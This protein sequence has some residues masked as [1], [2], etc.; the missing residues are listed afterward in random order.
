MSTHR[1]LD[2]LTRG[3]DPG[4]ALRLYILN[5][6]LYPAWH[7]VT[8][9]GAYDPW[10]VWWGVGAF[11]VGVGL[12]AG[13][14]QSTTRAREHGT[15]ACSWLVTL[16]FFLLAFANDMHPFYAVGSLMAVVFAPLVIR[17]LPA[18]RSYTVFVAC[19]GVGLFALEPQTIKVAFWAPLGIVLAFHY[20]RI[21]L[22]QA[23]LLL[24]Q[25]NQIELER[26]V[27]QRTEALVERSRELT[28]A[29]ERLRAEMEERRHLEEQ[30][31]F[32]QKM[33]AVGRLA[34]GVAHDFNNL[35][36]AIRGYAD[37]VHDALPPESPV[38]EDV[39]QI[40]KAGEQAKLITQQLLAFSRRDVVESTIL[41]PNKV[42]S[43]TGSMI[44]TF[45]GEDTEL[46]LELTE[47][48]VRIRANEV[49]L[50][51]VLVNLALNARDAM[52]EGGRL[53]LETARLRADEVK[54]LHRPPEG[55]VFVL[56]AVQDTGVG[57]DEETQSKCFDPF[58]TTKD[59]DRG[60]G[61]GLSIVYGIVDQSG[62]T[63]RVLSRPGRGARFEIYWPVASGAELRAERR[64]RRSSPGGSEHVLVVEDEPPV[65][66]LCQRVLDARGYTVLACAD[67]EEAIAIARELGDDLD[68][69]LTDVVMPRAN[70]F[71]LAER[72]GPICAHARV[73]FMSGQLNH[74]SLRERRLPP[75]TELLAKPFSADELAS[76]VREVLDKDRE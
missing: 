31:R 65:R 70:G 48:P 66:H 19:L 42:V 45:L 7:F 12:F 4:F 25:E 76:R 62:G 60:T 67:V 16:H 20:R 59:V 3:L 15:Y 24:V 35:L 34:G 55:E 8:P 6:L 11:F 5:G 21:S 38:R 33:E 56:L 17:S 44:G 57:M 74:P 75:G 29:N 58:F 52:P 53:I 54:E 28:R 71:E 18:L 61:L 69:V 50:G 46:V 9:E 2:A 68:L 26:R 73:L 40:Q 43:E 36:T 22:E 13:R 14:A 47:E 23:A 64:A 49:Q 41:D 63:I 37:L 27:A 1:S 30:L 72:I 51:Q 32:S 10:G 39:D